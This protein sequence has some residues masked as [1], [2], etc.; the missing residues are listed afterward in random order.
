MRR[1]SAT[2]RLAGSAAM[3]LIVG[4]PDRAAAYRPFDGTD[5]SVADPG[6]FEIE[7]GPAGLL[8]EGSQRTL[9]APAVGE[10]VTLSYQERDGQKVITKLGQAKQ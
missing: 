7:L 5:A 8:R 3:L 6:A 2:A 10:K 1:R 4:W 9:I